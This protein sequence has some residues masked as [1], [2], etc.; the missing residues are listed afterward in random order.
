MI[1]KTGMKLLLSITF[2][3]CVFL[4]SIDLTLASGDSNVLMLDTR[5][6]K[7]RDENWGHGKDYMVKLAKDPNRGSLPRQFTMCNSNFVLGLVRQQE[8]AP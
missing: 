7:G 4:G 2:V 8:F 5:N 6:L 1:A 3:V